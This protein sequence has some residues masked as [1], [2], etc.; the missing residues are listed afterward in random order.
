MWIHSCPEFK[1]QS[2]Q[3]NHNNNK[4]SELFRVLPTALGRGWEGEG[5]GSFSVSLSCQAITQELGN[6]ELELPGSQVWWQHRFF[7]VQYLSLHKMLQ[8]CSLSSVANDTETVYTAQLWWSSVIFKTDILYIYS[9]LYIINYIYYI[10][11]YIYLALEPGPFTP[12]TIL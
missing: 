3:K 7:S 4:I 5:S 1:P 9:I 8:P 6:V 11:I 10:Y 12:Q 2:H